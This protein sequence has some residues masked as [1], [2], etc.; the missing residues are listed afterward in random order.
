MMLLDDWLPAMPT[1]VTVERY[2]THARAPAGAVYAA[3]RR[4][5]LGGPVLRVLL[6]LRV[7][8][9]ALGGSRHARERLARLRAGAERL[10]LQDFVSA[11]FT[12]LAEH[13]EREI[14]RAGV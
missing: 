1:P 12:L 2:A 4:A 7:L 5:D 3:L 14:V 11:G 13:P 8:P 10:T 9:A 6:G